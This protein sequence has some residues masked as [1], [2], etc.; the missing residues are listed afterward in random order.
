MDSD[1]HTLKWSALTRHGA[2]EIKAESERDYLLP[3]Q[4]VCILGVLDVINGFVR[5]SG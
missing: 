2:G 5:H 1:P 4:R 3:E